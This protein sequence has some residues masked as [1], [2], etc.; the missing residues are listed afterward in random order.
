MEDFDPQETPL[1]KVRAAARVQRLEALCGKA[2]LCI[3]GYLYNA[4]IYTIEQ[5]ALIADELKLAAQGQ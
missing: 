3:E 1:D 4:H 5:R 2:A